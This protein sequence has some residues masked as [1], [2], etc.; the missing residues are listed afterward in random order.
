MLAVLGPAADK[1][2]KPPGQQ[3]GAM[4]I[5]DLTTAWLAGFGDDPSAGGCP[6]CPPTGPCP[7][8]GAHDGDEHKP[9]AHHAPRRHTPQS[10]P[11]M[12]S[13]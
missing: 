10:T 11:R 12:V 7:D 6:P 8:P 3:A 5:G 13:R 4:D 9:Q 1:Q 2:L